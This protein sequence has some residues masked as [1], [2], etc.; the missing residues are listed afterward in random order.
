[1]GS[2]LTIPDGVMRSAKCA[3]E[4]LSKSYVYATTKTASGWTVS[5]KPIERPDY[6]LVQQVGPPQPG[7]LLEV[8]IEE[9]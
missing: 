4:L 7:E 3:A 9:V 2:L 8:T 6:M 1:M 5:G